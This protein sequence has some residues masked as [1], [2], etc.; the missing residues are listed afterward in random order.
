VPIRVFF[1]SSA[2]GAAELIDEFSLIQETTRTSL[3]EVREVAR[4]LRPGVLEDLGLHNALAALA[5]EFSSRGI[6][7]RRIFTPGLPSLAPETELVICRV[8][9][10]ALTKVAR[11]SGA[12][13][14]DG[15]SN[16]YAAGSA[17]RARCSPHARTRWSN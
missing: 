12:E 16:G 9:Q 4:R 11:H 2:A 6:H 5:T 10:E 7:V 17:H 13:A 3:D 8:A 1:G 15:A 14:G